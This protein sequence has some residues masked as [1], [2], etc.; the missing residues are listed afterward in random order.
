MEDIKAEGKQ[1]PLYSKFLHGQ[2]SYQGRQRYLVDFS[3]CLLPSGSV[4]F[5]ICKEVKDMTATAQKMGSR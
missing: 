4:G 2:S 5:Q 3:S 1:Q